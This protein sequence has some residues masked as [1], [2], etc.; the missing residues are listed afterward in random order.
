VPD[1]PTRTVRTL[2]P[3]WI[4]V[5]DGRRLAA[6][7]WLPD[8]VQVGRVPAIL[9]HLPY[10]RRD[11]TAIRDSMIH[12]WFAARGYACIRTDITG[13][14]D[15]DGVL[16]GEYLDQELDDAVDVIAWAARQPWSSGSLGMMGIS[17]GGFNALQVA[18]RRPPQ[19]KA[20]VTACSTDDRYADDIHYMGGCMLTENP[21]WA[22]T[23]F[24]FNSRPPD[25]AIV[26]DGWRDV[27]LRRLEETG[28]WILDWLSH[29]RRDEFWRHGSVAEDY[30][31]IECAVLAVGGWA[32]GY[33]NAILRLLAGLSAPRLGII[34][35]W[36][37]GWPHA[38]RPGPQIG[39]LGEALRFWDCWLKDRDNGIMREP[40]LRA[41]VQDWSPPAPQYDIRPG[42]WVAE[43]AWPSP[44]IER[45]RFELHAGAA[46][47]DPREPSTLAP[48]LVTGVTGGCWDPYGYEGEFPTDQREDDGRSLTFDGRPLEVALETLG[49]PSVELDL[50]ID[51]PVGFVCVRLCDVAPDSR[52]LRVSYGL[53]NLTH[54]HGHDQVVPFTPGLHQRVT[55]PLN[56]IGHVFRPGHRIRVALSTAYWP[57][58]WPSPRPVALSVRDAVVLNL[59]VRR[60]TTE[61][62]IA[63]G[64]PDAA[65][66]IDHVVES[67]YHTRR[68]WEV[69]VGTGEWVVEFV[70]DRGRVRLADRDLTYWGRAHDRFSLRGNDPLSARVE[71][72]YETELSR[73][74]WRTRTVAQTVLTSTAETYLVTA[75]LEAW[76]G[77]TRVF[78][79][80]WDGRVARDGT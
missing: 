19:L 17:W 46:T 67:P 10:R 40:M 33:T 9:E 64:E 55:V 5:R 24:G 58:V 70:K 73:P 13:A 74:G 27:W 71:S 68:R 78:A 34:G 16:G 51:Q 1:S 22:A 76:E 12:P 72:T 26:G 47:G 36:G 56:D 75:S 2:D 43:A 77:E 35:P 42:R 63:F 52:S 44:T 66:P 41:W 25:P 59:P 28:P 6:T 32:D 18:A 21:A 7:I 65:R 3:V 69:D 45:G 8:D 79:R 49:Q 37:H 57:L 20:I 31:A 15:S 53:L 11:F 4:E 29:Q 62:S 23:M 80:T 54:L 50:T 14:G 39:F 30:G 61:P 48:L 38:A 60:S